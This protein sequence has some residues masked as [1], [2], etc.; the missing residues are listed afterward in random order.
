MSNSKVLQI[1][2]PV[3]I[4]A[5]KSFHHKSLF[6]LHYRMKVCRLVEKF[7]ERSTDSISKNKSLSNIFQ[8]VVKGKG[9]FDERMRLGDVLLVGF[10]FDEYVSET[11]LK[12][13]SLSETLKYIQREDIFGKELVDSRK[14]VRWV[15]ARRKLF[16]G[17][18]D[19]RDKVL[20]ALQSEE[21]RVESDVRLIRGL[22][23]ILECFE[24]CKYT[25]PGFYF[26]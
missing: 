1:Q 24:D 25:K 8:R 19:I 21:Q 6:I 22:E 17:L 18:M 7:L 16:I 20:S 9:T 15:D 5:E 14:F 10:H 26:D 11:A 2:T 12:Q 13:S 23:K 4:K 3:V